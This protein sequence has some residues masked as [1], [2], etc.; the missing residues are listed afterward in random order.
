MISKLL[1][2]NR[3]EIGH[4]VTDV[5]VRRGDRDVIRNV[6]ANPGARLSEA[7]ATGSQTQTGIVMGTPYYMSPE[8]ALGHT[9]DKIDLRSDIY[10]L[11]MIVYQMMTAKLPFESASWMQIPAR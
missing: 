3:S 9:G 4:A 5:I 10:S 1:V 11:G 8:Q 2:A 7:G 6:A